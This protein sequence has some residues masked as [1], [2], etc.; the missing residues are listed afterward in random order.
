MYSKQE[1]SL[2][3]K[4]FWTNFGQY[5]RPIAGAE[6][7]KVN[8][9]NYKTG[10]RHIYFRM[11]VRS[12]GASIAI[13]LR[14]SDESLRRHYFE[15]LKQ[16]KNLLE[17]ITGEEWDWEPEQ[18]AEDGNMISRISKTIRGV[19]IFLESDWPIIISFLKPRMIALD[20]FWL[21]VKDGLES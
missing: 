2:T 12:N 14:H 1:V 11:D 15:Q 13:E 19:N 17:Q 5:M 20:E 18:S 7:A 8:W 21:M 10:I 6:G 4:R 9:L 3:N 16:L